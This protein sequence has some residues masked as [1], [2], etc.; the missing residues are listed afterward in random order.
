MALGT[1]NKTYVSTIP[2]LDQREILNEALN[3]TNEELHFLDVME[4]TNRM[5]ETGNV[6]YH[7]FTNQELYATETIKTGSSV[8]D[9]S[10]GSG[11]GDITFVAT[12]ANGT[13][14]IRIGDTLM[15]PSGYAGYVYGKTA[16][17][18][19]DQID[20]KA[21][22]ST[23][24]T[25]NL[26]AAADQVVATFGQ[27]SGEGSGSPE[28]VRYSLDKDFNQVQIFK[29]KAVI[30]DI[31]SLNK[32]E[33]NFEGKPYYMY[34]AVHD[35]L[36]RFRGDIAFTMVIGQISDENFTSASPKLTDTGG[37]AV[38]T[39]K[40]VDQYI[41]DSGVNLT[42]VTVNLA[43]Y[44]TLTRS[45]NARRCPDTYYLFVGTEMNIAHDDMLTGL[46]T[47]LTSNGRIKMGEGS[48][49]MLGIDTFKLYGRT[50][51]K[52]HMPM[53]DHQNV[54]N[55]TGSAGY[56]KKAYYL[57]EGQIKTHGPGGGMVDRFRCRYM[58]NGDTDSRY[59]ER[60]TGGL[61][62]IP[63]DDTDLLNVTHKA[64]MGLEV[65]G[66][67]QCASTKLS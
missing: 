46:N 24:T 53:L 32:I 33:V 45:L 48:E 42:G 25:A 9:N 59:T 29:N 10:G 56:H 17:A 5:V 27:A 66:A 49:L 13:T 18:G 16:D 2:F 26:A 62:P 11:Q 6:T 50:Y 65:L 41:A 64:I 36:M 4:L 35:S 55:F 67:Y 63:T 60:L 22:L 31:E 21:V 7:H 39:T 20:V 40:G 3:I 34:K 12:S 47:A 38:Q 52:I 14:K 30:T 15:F 43:H 8:T 58:N 61:A 54:I 19:G 57:P 51:K 23:V 1:I 28:A 44:A 37:N